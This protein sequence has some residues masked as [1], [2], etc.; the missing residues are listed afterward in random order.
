MDLQLRPLIRADR[1]AALAVHDQLANEDFAFL[2]HWRAQMDWDS[3]V[4]ALA[5]YREGTELPDG[6]VRSA[7]LVAHFGSELV[8]RISIRFELNDYLSIRGGHIGYAVAPGSRGRGVATEMLR[9]GLLIARS[10]GVGPVLMICG[11]DN[12]P[13]AKVIEKC[14]G[15]LEAVVH[16]PD[17]VAGESKSRIRRY[18][19]H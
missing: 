19:I 12:V 18:W 3:Y 8:G 4:E 13:S 17:A 14:G 1:D 7:F 16:D 11:D 9:Q 15:V 6:V 2:L 10:E 5:T